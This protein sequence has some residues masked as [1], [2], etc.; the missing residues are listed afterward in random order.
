MVEED[1]TQIIAAFTPYQAVHF[2]HNLQRGDR[3]GRSF[4]W[5]SRRSFRLLDTMEQSVVLGRI[6]DAMEP[7]VIMVPIPLGASKEE[8]KKIVLQHKHDL[9]RRSFLDENGKLDLQKS[10]LAGDND[11]FIGKHPENEPKV[12]RLRGAS[13]LGRMD[14]VKYFQ[15][16]V[17][18][19]TGVPKAYLGVERDLHSVATMTWQDVE[20]ARLCRFIQKEMA[21][22][23]RYIYDLQ[24]IMQRKMPK[25][26]EPNKQP[27]KIVYP[28]IS[29]IDEQM[30]VTV[31]KMRWEIAGLARGLE[32]PFE[33]VMTNILNLPEETAKELETRR[34]SS[35]QPVSRQSP[36]GAGDLESLKRTVFG[37]AQMAQSVRDLRDMI[38]VIRRERLD[39]AVEL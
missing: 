5:G 4:L 38:T 3:Y 39:R 16:K 32:V 22:G 18:M 13:N 30:R 10:P 15:D 23:Q 35:E 14:D 26:M 6:K 37:N 17:F 27:Y 19:G 25:T 12:E 7:I 28:S 11:L 34:E 31:E 24:L 29:F 20:Y 36:E 9:G 1:Q 33:W 2:R 8:A 21:G